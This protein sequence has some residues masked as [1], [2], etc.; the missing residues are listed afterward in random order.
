MRKL[1]AVAALVMR[2]DKVARAIL[3]VVSQG[4]APE[5][6]VPRGMGVWQAFRVLTPSLYR[7][8]VRTATKRFAT[9]PAKSQG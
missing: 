5:V 1:I 7:W 3:D 9:T 2:A 6:S 4:K 8:G